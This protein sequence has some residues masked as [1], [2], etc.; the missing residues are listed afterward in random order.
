[1]SIVSSDSASQLIDQLYPLTNA[2]GKIILDQ[3]AQVVRW[4]DR[5]TAAR[6]MA[7]DISSGVSRPNE[8]AAA[9][10]YLERLTK[11]QFKPVN[12]QGGV[13]KRDL[14]T[15]FSYIRYAYEAHLYDTTSDALEYYSLIFPH[16]SEKV[17][18]GHSQVACQCGIIPPVEI[19]S[20]FCP[21]CNRPRKLCQ[22]P[23][24]Y[25]GR[26]SD[27]GGRIPEGMSRGTIYR[28]HMTPEDA[29]AHA[30][31]EF[32]AGISLNA[33][34]AMVAMQIG[35][36][37]SELSQSSPAQMRIRL[38]TLQ[39]QLQAAG[40]DVDVV[41]QISDEMSRILDDN[42]QGSK[43]VRDQMNKWLLVL[44]KLTEQER[45]NRKAA[46]EFISVEDHDRIIDEL[47]LMFRAGIDRIMGESR[48]TVYELIV[49]S[50]RENPG[51]DPD[52]IAGRVSTGL[53]NATRLIE[54]QL[55]AERSAPTM[56]DDDI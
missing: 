35:Q 53:M 42:K 50:L 29:A 55:I 31:M 37:S 27:H 24:L 11:S 4:S 49:E 48:R 18:C 20:I 45:E 33:E 8:I 26:C 23:S 43:P 2:D 5:H 40:D 21:E 56:G 9:F 25:N 7:Q 32:E 6:Q 14:S 3:L 13:L 17:I 41:S 38:N 12:G 15:Y 10:S 36:L 54:G 52:D 28:Q 1:M 22:A 51:A 30:T 19:T 16:E 46:A 39:R 34:I 44:A 47:Y